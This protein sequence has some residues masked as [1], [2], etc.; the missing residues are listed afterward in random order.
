MMQPQA[1]IVRIKNI[2]TDNNRKI[3]WKSYGV[4]GKQLLGELQLR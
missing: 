1:E 2:S 4:D 3:M